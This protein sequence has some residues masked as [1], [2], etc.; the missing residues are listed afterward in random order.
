MAT[1]STT[2]VLMLRVLL[3]DMGPTYTYC[4]DR[5]E[6]ILAVAATYVQTEVNLQNSYAVSVEA[7][8]ITHDPIDD[9]IF[10]N[11]MVLKAACILDQTGLRARAGL[12]GLKAVMGPASLQV[13]GGVEGYIKTIEVGACKSYEDM[14][15]RYLFGGAGAVRAVLSPFVSNLFDAQS[16]NYG[17]HR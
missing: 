16:L 14:K 1:W 2:G 10:M 12:D 4:D 15:D 5:L 13:S 8:T 7:V 9:T 11:L 6:Q 3:G 17:G